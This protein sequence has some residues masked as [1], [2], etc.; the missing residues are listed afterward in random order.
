MRVCFDVH[1]VDEGELYERAKAVLDKFSEG[2]RWNID[3]EA[4][5]EAQ[6]GEG[7]VTL[8]RGEVTADHED[9]ET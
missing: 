3:I 8:W 4:H 1:G 6:T 9:L 2:R 5:A 7:A